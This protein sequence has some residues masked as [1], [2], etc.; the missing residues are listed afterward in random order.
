MAADKFAVTVFPLL[1]RVATANGLAIDTKGAKG[2]HLTLE[3]TAKQ[4]TSPTCN[5]KI[6]RRD[7][8]SGEYV[9]LP[10]GAFA[11]QVAE[12]TVAL[13]IYPGIAETSN[14]SVSDVL[15]EEIRAVFTLGGTSTPGFTFS[16]GGTLIN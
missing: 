5:V 13:T 10:D 7:P 11:Q 8:V 15:S 3:I 9:D 12:A 16:L 2:V 1:A 4:G 14:V 6:Q